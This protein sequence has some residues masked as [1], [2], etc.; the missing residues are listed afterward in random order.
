MTHFGGF[1][2][3]CLREVHLWTDWYV[4]E[5]LS[6]TRLSQPG[7]T[8]RMLFQR[9]Y[10]DPSAIEML[11][12]EVTSFHLSPVSVNYDPIIFEATLILE[13]GEFFWTDSWGD[14]QENKATWVRAKGLSW[15]E[16]SDWMGEKLRYGSSL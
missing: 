13:D 11:F 7:T 15:R 10:R 1:H 14:E 4:Q 8:L 5:D 2:D 16:A 6:A 9:Q 12:Q 3:G